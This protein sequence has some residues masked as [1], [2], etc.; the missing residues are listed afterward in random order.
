MKHKMLGTLTWD[1]D[2]EWHVSLFGGKI[3]N[4]YKNQDEAVNFI[5]SELLTVIDDYQF[6]VCYR[7]ENRVL[8][9]RSY[10][11]LKRDEKTKKVLH[12]SLSRYEYAKTHYF[13]YSKDRR[14]KIIDYKNPDFNQ[15]T[16]HCI[17]T[18]HRI[19]VIF[20]SLM[21][22]TVAILGT[23]LGLFMGSMNNDM[24]KAIESTTN[25]SANHTAM[26]IMLGVALGSA[27][28]VFAIYIA[29]YARYNKL[30]RAKSTWHE[31]YS[32]VDWRK[33]YKF[34]KLTRPF[35]TILSIVFTGAIIAFG[36][37][38]SQSTMFDA[39]TSVPELKGTM[40]IYIF[41]TFSVAAF[42]YIT[43][44]YIIRFRVSLAHISPTLL[45]EEGEIIYKNWLKGLEV[46]KDEEAKAFHPVE[47][48]MLY[49]NAEIINENPK[50]ATL[51]DKQIK[52]FRK[53]VM[54][55]RDLI[56]IDKFSKHGANKD[57]LAAAK[58]RYQV[59]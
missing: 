57:E 3:K 19:S 51:S 31:N 42:A 16:R 52:Q 8:G 44:Y 26:L 53:D 28:S 29:R 39:L 25:G 35:A 33:Y 11:L 14:R 38:F 9:R 17:S 41:S 7:I 45:T 18:K 27:A 55:Y 23:L 54:T 10:V 36:I 32:N 1:T 50:F 34:A 20:F 37:I 2:L 4:S 49:P 58:A 47:E 15:L 5:E 46:S 56:I 12:T 48:H 13:F 43:T 22:L 21:A 59:W 6:E 40:I 30:V 24:V